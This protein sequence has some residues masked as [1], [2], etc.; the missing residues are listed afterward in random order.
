MRNP[1][2][3]RRISS[4]SL[5]PDVVD[6]IV[7][8]TKNP[9]PML[10]KLDALADYP[11]YVQFTLTGYGPDVE[12]G[13]PDKDTVL[14]PAFIYLAQRI[15]PQRVVWRYDPLFLS[16][17]YTAAYHAERFAAMAAQLQGYT[18]KCIISFMDY[19]K[20]T[21]SHMQG[22]GMLP[23]GEADM[24]QLA[25]KLAAIAQHHGMKME[26]CAEKLD[27]AEC[28]IGHAQ[29]IDADLLAQIGG[30]PLQVDKDKNQRAVCGC[31]SSI[32]IGQ[33]DSCAHGCLYCYANHS[34]K[35]VQ[36]NLQ[37]HLV[38]SPLLCGEPSEQDI[39]TERKVASSK[40]LQTDLFYQL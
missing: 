34:A 5:Q 27:L 9:L 21:A 7:L 29:C 35:A 13:L 40:V 39:I 6:G 28:G 23:F 8:W 4:V 20:G 18:H 31:A 38:S 33:Y 12:P 16:R 25:A 32:D 22:L 24:R 36:A 11:Y 2:N 30:Y 15:G 17:R 1:V 37:G 14:L 10:D 19:Y 26:T 3:P